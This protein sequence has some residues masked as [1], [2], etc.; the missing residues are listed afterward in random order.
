MGAVQVIAATSVKIASGFSFVDFPR[1]L[2]V[3]KW[4]AGSFGESGRNWVPPGTSVNDQS[5]EV[6]EFF[7]PAR[8]GP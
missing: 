6:R 7:G 5:V 2:D 3:R 4:I 8:S 1:A